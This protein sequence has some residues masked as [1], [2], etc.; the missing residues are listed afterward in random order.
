MRGSPRL[1]LA[2]IHYTASPIT[3]GVESIVAVHARLLR[4][5]GHDVLVVAGRGDAAVVPE[6]DSRHPEVEA[7]ARRLAKGD[8]ATPDFESLRGRLVERLRPLL[9]GRDVVIAHNVLTMPF[10]LPLAAAL[11]DLGRPLVAWTHDVAWVNPR[12]ADYRRPG[13]PWS[14]LR[15]SQPGVRYVA[16]SRLRQGEIAELM[17][18]PLAAVTVVPNGVDPAAFW[19]LGPRALDLVHRAGLEGADPLVLVPVR[20]T[21]RKRLELALDTAVCLRGTHPGLRLVV[22]GPLG[23]HS[24]DN[25]A[26][27]EELRMQRAR[28]DLD[29]VVIFLHEFAGPDGEHPV[30]DRTIAELYR[31]ADLVLLP[32]ESEG[33]GLP[34]LE[35]GL[36]RAPL[37]CADIP[38]LREVAA[39]GTWSFPAGSAGD[40]VAA[41]AESA[42]RSRAARLFRRTLRTYGWPSVLERIEKLLVEAHHGG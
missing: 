20:I 41:V 8:P 31:M 3:G 23:P 40:A 37:V 35:A 17:G 27:A 7:V 11:T 21:R 38:V 9:A 26:Y 15:E 29:G 18:M 1:S 5:A 16:I 12:Y 24:A 39:G 22:S 10:N 30:D 36:S 34:V 32:S 2:L 42:L 28:L 4:Q 25:V 33:F 13:W 6:V 14:M 19:G